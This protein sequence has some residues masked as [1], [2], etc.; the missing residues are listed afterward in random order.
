MAINQDAEILQQR[1]QDEQILN[2]EHELHNQDLQAQVEALVDHELHNQVLQA[3]VEA[4]QEH[5]QRNQDLQDQVEALE[6]HELQ[7]QALQAQVQ[8]LVVA[9]AAAADTV[10]P[11]RA[12]PVPAAFSHH[13]R[14]VTA[15]AAADTVLPGRA[16]PVPAAFSQPQDQVQAL[17]DATAVAAA[18][19][20]PV[21]APPV[22]AHAVQGFQAQV[23]N[24]N[25]ELQDQV[26]NL[27]QKLQDQA[28]VLKDAAVVAAAEAPTTGTPPAPPAFVLAPALANTAAAY[29]DLTST[30]GA[31]QFKGAIKPLTSPPIAFADP[32][33]LQTL[34]DL[35]LQKSQVYSWKHIWT[36]PVINAA[37]G[38]VTKRNLLKEY[39][40]I[41]LNAITAHV[42]TY[43]ATRTKQAQDS[44]MACHCLLSSL[45]FDFLKVLTHETQDYHLPAI[46]AEDGPIPCG[47][48]L[49]KII[50]SKTHVDSRAEG[51]DV[52]VNELMADAVAKCI[53]RKRSNKRATPTKEQSQ[54][55]A[56]TKEV[57]QLKTKTRR[58]SAAVAFASPKKKP[59]K[60]DQHPQWDW[61]DVIPTDGEPT[62]KDFNGKQYH[63]GC[64]FHPGWWVC[65]TTEQCS[66]N[67]DNKPPAF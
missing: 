13:S 66:K 11:G 60:K 49:L 64:K 9:A 21:G 8:A 16:P 32:S 12:P 2:Q 55:L 51:H 6:D 57:K 29:I 63:I 52:G 30:S 41:P 36:V 39:D 3:Q 65:H 1:L 38:V 59:P 14:V 62:T 28:Q 67:P 42:R 44:F 43:Y 18:A 27:N 5:E 17:N 35:L 56:L 23:Q 34:L 26:Q 54:I 58:P 24:L 4:L 46:V 50:I 47:P 15:A 48:L 31:I 20:L 10:L 25:Q 45:S 61:K 40:M 37:T 53:A 19:A 7:N 22:P 33:D